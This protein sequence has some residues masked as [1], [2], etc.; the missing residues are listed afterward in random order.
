MTYQELINQILQLQEEGL[1]IFNVGQSTLGKNILATHLGEYSGPQVIV[2]AGIHAREWITSLLLIEQARYL[3]NTQ[4]VEGG[5]IYFVFITNP[6]GVEIA[7]DGIDVVNCDITKNYLISANNGSLDFSTYKANINLVDLNTN[8][9]ANWGQGSQNVF[10]PAT[11]NFVGFYPNSEREVQNLIDLT[12][13]NQPLITISY[14]SKGNVI[15]YGFEGQSEEDITRDRQIGEV[16]SETTGYPLI[17]TENST[18]G[19]KDWSINTLKIPAYTIEVGD[20]NLSHPLSVETLP[21]IYARNKDIP[22]IALNLA[23]EYAKDIDFTSPIVQNITK[24]KTYERNAKSY[25][26]R[27][28]SL[29]GRRNSHWRSNR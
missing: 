23:K 4:Q 19:Y 16:L 14:H 29:L 27:L 12:L 3:Y 22:L 18:G 28:Q 25:T 5:G 6:D 10:C 2:Q 26:T 17:F 15:Y 11:E 13:K 24:E 7:L 1:E 9:D 20:E 8:F 21:E